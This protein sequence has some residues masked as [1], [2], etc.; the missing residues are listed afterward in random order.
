[1]LLYLA[2]FIPLAWSKFS[3]SV[4]L[5]DVSTPSTSPMIWIT[6]GQNIWFPM[7]QTLQKIITFTTQSIAIKW[8]YQ[9]HSMH[10]PFHTKPV[11]QTTSGSILQYNVDSIATMTRSVWQ[12]VYFAFWV[13]FF[14]LVVLYLA[15]RLSMYFKFDLH[16]S[17]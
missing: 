4:I 1:M 16:K 6:F 9:K 13:H 8:S 17:V 12:I 14:C 5:S 11:P 3:A 10:V 7:L 2:T 15:L